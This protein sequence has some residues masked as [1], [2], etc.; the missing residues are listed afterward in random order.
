MAKE[1]AATLVGGAAVGRRSQSACSFE[2]Y[3]NLIRKSYD[4]F[5]GYKF[6]FLVPLIL[7]EISMAS[8]SF[9]L[10]KFVFID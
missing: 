10:P 6:T 7:I 1:D 5:L 2:S 4:A 9:L 8:Q 3:L